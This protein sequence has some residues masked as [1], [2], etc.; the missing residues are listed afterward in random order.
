MGR[1]CFVKSRAG[2]YDALVAER[3]SDAS[4]PGPTGEPKGVT[5]CS[6]DEG[7]ART[8]CDGASQPHAIATA[9]FQLRPDAGAIK[10]HWIV[11]GGTGG[12]FENSIR[13]GQVGKRIPVRE[14]GGNFNGIIPDGIAGK[15]D[16]E[17]AVR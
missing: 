14:I 15:S 5:A 12:E 2:S 7:V 3:A 13:A 1:G 8:F 9:S 11:R 16:F 17:D 6:C 4:S 10:L